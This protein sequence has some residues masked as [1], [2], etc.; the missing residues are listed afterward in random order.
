M[1]FFFSILIATIL[2]TSTAM[3]DMSDF[4]TDKLHA[5][6]KTGNSNTIEKEVL[7][8]C[9]K[10]TMLTASTMEKAK[11]ISKVAIDEYDFRA[12]FCMKAVINN[13]YSQPEFENGMHHDVCKEDIKLINIVCREFV[14]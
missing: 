3:A 5:W 11:F 9:S 12:S 4:Y 8:S 1:K 6:I 2:T 10:L 7:E 13:I 14:Y